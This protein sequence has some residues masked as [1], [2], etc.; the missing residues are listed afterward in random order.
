MAKVQNNGFKQDKSKL[1]Q[2]FIYNKVIQQAEPLYNSVHAV[3]IQTST[4]LQHFSTS[5]R[6]KMDKLMEFGGMIFL[7]I[8]SSKA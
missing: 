3:Q 1:Q 7:K 2:Y 4:E 6:Q 8:P 5:A